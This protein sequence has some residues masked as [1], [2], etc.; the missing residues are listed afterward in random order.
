MCYVSEL[1]TH[2]DED[3]ISDQ[4]SDNSQSPLAK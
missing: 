4:K 2:C 3:F 1:P